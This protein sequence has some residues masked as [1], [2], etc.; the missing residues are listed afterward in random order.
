M[1]G[2]AAL[3]LGASALHAQTDLTHLWTVE[4]G[5]EAFFPDAG[6]TARGMALNP[7]TG[8]LLVA[9]RA[10]GN[11]VRILDPD[12]GDVIGTLPDQD[13]D[14][15]GATFVINKVGVADDGAIYV[16]NLG[17]AEANFTV[18]RHADETSAPTVAFE[19]EEG[20]AVAPEGRWGDGFSVI[21]A[22]N[23]T[24]IAVGGAFETDVLVLSTTDGENFDV[25]ALV[26]IG[27]DTRNIVL[28]TEAELVWHRESGTGLTTGYQLDGS[29]AAG[30]FEIGP[31]ALVTGAFDLAYDPVEDVYWH[32]GV[33]G[34][35]G[36]GNAGQED[37]FGDIIS[38]DDPETVA[39]RTEWGLEFGASATEGGSSNDNLNAAGDAVID[40][41]NEVVY[42]MYPNNTISAWSF[43]DETSV[44]SWNLYEH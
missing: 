2:A 40:F 43:A 7:V 12:N 16:G 38:S 25:E 14:A 18:Y 4:G 35:F 26:D 29:G 32:A 21:G 8:N 44:D 23:D 17:V 33:P 37:H 28:D 41:E 11:A 22:G 9:S 20:A 19:R 42:F 30:D 31:T 5:E 24:L 27:V 6:D 10:G 39:L 1:T 34:N 36:G 15:V 3:L 13:Y